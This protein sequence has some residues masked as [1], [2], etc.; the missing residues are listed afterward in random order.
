MVL[1]DVP[2]IIVNPDG[3]RPVE[4]PQ[5]L[6]DLSV[7]PYGGGLLP[8]PHLPYCAEVAERSDQGAI[9]V[10]IEHEDAG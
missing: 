8:S 6:M 1:N 3:S 9:E 2:L 4:S 10:M 7:A 5:Q